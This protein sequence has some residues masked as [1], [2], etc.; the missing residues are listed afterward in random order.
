MARKTVAPTLES[1]ARINRQVGLGADE[2]TGRATMV[3]VL[4]AS[5][6]FHQPGA[7]SRRTVHARARTLDE[8]APSGI[9]PSGRE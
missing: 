3:F 8:Q 7:M 5:S 6:C 4:E 2:V 9:L 1:A